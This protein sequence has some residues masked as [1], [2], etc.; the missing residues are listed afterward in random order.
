[1]TIIW[2]TEDDRR[3]AA[4]A[5]REL[6]ERDELM[7]TFIRWLVD[8][9]APDGLVTVPEF[10]AETEARLLALLRLERA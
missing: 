6:V 3:R 2:S 8:R 4:E 1:M 10:T 5:R 7:T 9:S